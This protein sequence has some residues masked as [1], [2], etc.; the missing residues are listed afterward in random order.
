M[1]LGPMASF[2]FD[3]SLHYLICLL[4]TSPNVSSCSIATLIYFAVDGYYIAY[5]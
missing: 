3:D 1:H 4:I 5:K 2:R